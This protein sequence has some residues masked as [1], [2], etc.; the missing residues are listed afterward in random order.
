M[1]RSNVYGSPRRGPHPLVLIAL[2]VLLVGVLTGI[3]L[4]FQAL[5]DADPIGTVKVAG[6][7]TPA[8]ASSRPAPPS[9]P[10][11]TSA[12]P[13]SAPPQQPQQFGAVRGQGSNLC[14][15]VQ[16]DQPT[17]G[18]LLMILP[19][20]PGSPSQR[21]QR[22][23]TGMMVNGATGLCI[24]VAGAAVEDNA[25]VQQEPC[26]DAP[27]QRWALFL[28]ADGSASFGAQH[29]GR[30]LDVQGGGTAPGTPVQQFGCNGT[31]AQR[32]FLQPV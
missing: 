20:T 5:N 26:G 11:P 21:W 14:L 27:H 30:C 32:W 1:T 10:P 6:S 16:P 28:D 18:G 9:S 12:P 13:S 23:P 22:T 7:P 2:G 4:G 8:P 24:T 15:D 29:S 3:A 17:A 31:P 19:C 25:R